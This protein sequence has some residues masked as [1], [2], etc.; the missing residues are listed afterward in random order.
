VA[1]RRRSGDPPP[2]ADLICDEEIAEAFRLVLKYQFATSPED[3]VLRASRLLGFQAMHAQ[4][5]G[6]LR[7]VLKGLVERGELEEKANGMIHCVQ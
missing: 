7:T 2:K 5:A 6:R 1:V 3:L 4:T